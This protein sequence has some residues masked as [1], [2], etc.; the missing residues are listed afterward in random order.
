MCCNDCCRTTAMF[1]FQRQVAW[2]LMSSAI[3]RSTGVRSGIADDIGRPTRETGHGK[4]ATC[5]VSRFSFPGLY[6]ARFVLERNILSGGGMGQGIQ[7]PT[8]VQASGGSAWFDVVKVLYEPTQVFERVRE[9]PNFLAPFIAIC[10]V[11]I[12]MNGARKFGRSRTRSNT[13]VG[14]YKTFTT[15]NHALPP[16][17]CTTVG[18]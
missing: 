16:L 11:Q 2:M 14:S 5:P 10:V 6:W 4:R 15:S 7:Q 12:A 9:R 3:S 17:A 8:V 1:G 13:C 18:C